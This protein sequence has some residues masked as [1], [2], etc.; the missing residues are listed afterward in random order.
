MAATTPDL[1][2]TLFERA[3]RFVARL[4]QHEGEPIET[5][6]DRADDVAQ[7][8]PEDEQ[9]ELLNAHP[10]IGAVP[11]TVSALSYAE[12]GY[13]SDPG[14]D[15][16]QARLERLNEEYERRLGFRF[17]VFVAGRS[18][19]EIADVMETRMSASREEELARGLSDVVA[20]ARDRLAKVTAVEEGSNA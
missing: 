17:V 3:P 9:V 7:A 1:L 6:L 8:M 16:L 4:V 11:S 13:D 2:A 10:R 20:I 12:Q 18:R 5:V 19:S 15:D 14:T